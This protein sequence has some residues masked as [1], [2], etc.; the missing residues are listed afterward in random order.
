MDRTV[1]YLP[2]G[3]MIGSVGVSPKW[4]ILMVYISRSCD[5]LV[6]YVIKSCNQITK[7]GNIDS[8][9]KGCFSRSSLSVT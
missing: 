4:E 6:T 1:I 9:H 5:W 2:V 7:K 3:H 8:L